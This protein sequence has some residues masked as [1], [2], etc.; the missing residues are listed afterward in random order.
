MKE[1]KTLT[2]L[3]KSDVNREIVN[4]VSAVMHSGIG[5]EI[6]ARETENFCTVFG[7]SVYVIETLDDLSMIHTYFES[8]INSG[9]WASLLEAHSAF[10][11]AFVFES[12]DFIMLWNIN[13]NDGGPT[14]YIPRSVFSQCPNVELSIIDTH[15]HLKIADRHKELSS[16]NY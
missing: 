5:S 11:D 13:N 8:E 2:S 1:F 12:G 16:V 15:G 6:Y 10:D 7:G 3:I 9:E 14:Y 4:D